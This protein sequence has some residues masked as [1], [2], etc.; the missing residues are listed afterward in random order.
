MNRFDSIL[1]IQISE[2]WMNKMSRN[3]K[4]E[5]MDTRKIAKE[6]PEG[7][8]PIG[9]QKRRDLGKSKRKRLKTEDMME[10]RKIQS[11][12]TEFPKGS[13]MNGGLEMEWKK[14]MK[15]PNRNLMMGVM[16]NIMVGKWRLVGNIS[17]MSR[18]VFVGVNNDIQTYKV[19]LMDGQ[20][21]GDKGKFPTGVSI[22]EQSGR[23]S[24]EGMKWLMLPMNGP[25]AFEIQS[26][27][28]KLRPELRGND[29]SSVGTIEIRMDRMV[30]KSRRSE[31]NLNPFIRTDPHY[32][33]WFWKGFGRI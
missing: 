8:R 6:N 26:K 12:V 3:A 24:E 7:L 21:K 29:R 18:E 2:Y 19:Q 27:Q 33:E 17:E 10:F 31:V 5:W 13:E 16:G 23:A 15:W 28:P 14:P 11:E 25:K 30:R 1:R 22:N 32:A 4:C 20:G 9:W